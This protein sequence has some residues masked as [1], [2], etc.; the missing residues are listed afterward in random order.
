MNPAEYH[1]MAAVEHDHW[2]YQGLRDLIG[3]SLQS[4]L[5][6]SRFEPAVLDAGCGTG[7]NLAFLQERL[8]PGY[9]GGFDASSLA[10]EYAR[11][12]VPTADLYL[13]D[14]C[15]PELHVS[16]FDVILSCDVIYVPGMAAAL[17]GLKTL[18]AA[19]R[20][21]GLLILNLPAFNWLRSRHDLAVHTSERFTR[22]QVGNL[23]NQLGLVPLRLTY[24]VCSLFP[25]I[26]LAR[27]PSIL[28]PGQD[29]GHAR[30]D[31]R[32]P[33]RWINAALR[34]LLRLENQAIGRGL[35]CPWG[36]SIFAVGRKP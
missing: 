21:G 4:D 3:R 2:W 26:V 24:R 12:K 30:S 31:V 7:E 35:C 10:L 28:F 13:S 22:K 5:D 17:Q 14:I 32:L 27:L 29:A 1:V 33:P 16:Q 15:H 9:L 34:S 18:S 25:A 23:L 20:P 8:S 11:K 6:R 36:T 19:L